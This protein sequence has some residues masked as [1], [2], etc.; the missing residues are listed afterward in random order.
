VFSTIT[1]KG[2]AKTKPADQPA[3]DDLV[4][5]DLTASAPNQVWLT[6]I[7]EHKT[8]EGELY[9]CAVKDLFANQIVGWSIDS[10]MKAS[11]VVAA[12][13]DAWLRRGRPEGVVVHF[14]RGSRFGSREYI[15]ACQQ[16]QVR[17]SMG[18]AYT[19]AD[20]AWEEFTP[21]LAWDVE[22]RKIIYTT[23]AIESL[24]AR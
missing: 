9:L 16:F 23:N 10:R 6:D 8:A 21:F 5:W 20:N 15:R 7:T 19:C 24:N 22:I 11:L 18:Q 17:C 1:R 3:D 12:L 14:D 4:G 2:R 13:T